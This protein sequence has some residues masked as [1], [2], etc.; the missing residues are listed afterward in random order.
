MAGSV[1]WQFCLIFRVSDT[2][3]NKMTVDSQMSLCWNDHR[4][5]NLQLTYMELIITQN[6]SAN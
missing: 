5:G 3:K 2:Q 6:I 4:S 1:Q